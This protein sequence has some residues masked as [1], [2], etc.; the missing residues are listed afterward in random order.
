MDNIVL[1]N[2]TPVTAAK[3]ECEDLFWAVEATISYVIELIRIIEAGRRSLGVQGI[4][5]S[6]A[7]KTHAQV[8]GIWVHATALDTISGSFAHRVF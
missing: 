6:F 3:D 1:P 8:G 4:D 5:I 2:G 7:L